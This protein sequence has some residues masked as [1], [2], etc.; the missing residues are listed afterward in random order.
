MLYY[1]KKMPGYA[2]KTYYYKHA[3]IRNYTDIVI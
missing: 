2:W 1:A 3:L